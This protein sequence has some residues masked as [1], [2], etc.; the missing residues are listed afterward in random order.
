[1]TLVV[2]RHERACR[3]ETTIRMATSYPAGQWQLGSTWNT[4][5]ETNITKEA[6]EQVLAES[7]Q[8]LGRLE[9]TCNRIVQL[10]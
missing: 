2:V 8:G 1:M 4:V 7:K 3:L 5:G 6:V 10:L 9:N